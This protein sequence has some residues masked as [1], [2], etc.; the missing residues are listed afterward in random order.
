MRVGVRDFKKAYKQV[1]IDG[2]EV[3][4]V[5]SA[6][7]TIGIVIVVSREVVNGVCVLFVSRMATAHGMCDHGVTTS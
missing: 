1:N 3:T 5:M 7:L 6:L 2:I 4:S